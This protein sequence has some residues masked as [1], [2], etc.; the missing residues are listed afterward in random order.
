M[1]MDLKRVKP[2]K[3]V[4]IAWKVFSDPQWR[5]PPK[6]HLEF[7]VQSGC[8]KIGVWAKTGEPGF[9]ASKTRDKAKEGSL[10]DRCTDLEPMRVKL[11]RVIACEDGH[12]QA[13]EMLVPRKSDRR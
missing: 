6:G 2:T 9:H 5:C 12:Y 13:L 3:K 4:I 11:R 8:V 1:C 10:Y 7:S